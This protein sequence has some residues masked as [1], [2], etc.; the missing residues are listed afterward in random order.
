MSIPF[1]DLKAQF[2]RLENEIR[3]SMDRVLEHGQFIMGP[4]VGEL[5][6]K[7]AAFVGV[8][9][10]V[11][12]GSGT[13][14]LFM[15]LMAYGIG[16]GDAVFAPTFTF[17]ASVEV[18]ALLGATPVFVDVDP[19]T[20]N[21]DADNLERVCAK[22]RREGKLRPRAVIA[23]DMFGIPA[24]YTR[25]TAVAATQG[26]RVISD[27]AQSFGAT[28]QGQAAGKMGDIS[29]TSFFPGKTI[30]CYG[31]GGA[32]FTDDGEIAETLRSVRV[33][34]KGTH[35]Y[36]NVRI[37]LNARLDTL[38]AAILLPKLAV[39][40]DELEARQA[41]AQRYD[42][43]L[44]N[45]VQTPR[46]PVG[47]RSAWAQ[48]AILCD[49]RDQLQ[50]ALKAAG[51]PTTIYYPKPLHLQTAFA[52]LQGEEGDFPVSEAISRRVLSL[53]MHPYLDDHQAKT[54]IDAT[55]QALHSIRR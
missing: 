17:I 20:F 12:C 47:S 32:L 53:P 16:P 9:H 36:D 52:Y 31:D 51:V 35:K 42:N 37:G 55:A 10:A 30:G 8:E 26:V 43:H 7:L 48:Y 41:A 38:Q 19:V 33:H 40:P 5:E 15:A 18:I 27:A 22:V 29:A 28:Y 34:G 50:E 3:A 11:T 23:V 6:E 24:D 54:I 49:E 25:I 46:V 45:L 1:I 39:L 2:S 44:G 4:E 21:L 13:D 14:A